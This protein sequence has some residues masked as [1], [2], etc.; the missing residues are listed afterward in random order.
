MLLH[1][2]I[3]MVLRVTEWLWV[4]ALH[5]P[6]AEE[7]LKALALTCRSLSPHLR[8]VLF[9]RIR[10]KN[11]TCFDLAVR[12]NALVACYLLLTRVTDYRNPLWVAPR[13]ACRARAVNRASIHRFVRMLR[14]HLSRRTSRPTRSLAAPLRPSARGLQWRE[15]IVQARRCARSDGFC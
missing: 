15:R 6:A 5:D 4:D 7:A 10:I 2:P 8:I 11:G 3:E 12:V 14:R 9:S 1:L 13:R